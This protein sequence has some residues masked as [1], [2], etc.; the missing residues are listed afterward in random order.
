MTVSYA[1]ALDL[2][3]TKILAAVVDSEG[4]ALAT[5]RLSTDAGRGPDAVADAMADLLQ[6]ACARAGV[7]RETLAGLGVSAAG[8]LDA[9]RGVVSA[10]PNL[11]GWKDVSLGRMLAARTGL[12]VVLENDANAAAVGEHVYGAGRGSRNMVFITVSTGIGGGVI[13]DGRLYRGATGAAGEIGHMIVAHAGERCGC[14]RLGCLEAYASGT[15]IARDAERAAHEGRSPALA[16]MR[17]RGEPLNTEAVAAA[18]EAGDATAAAILARAAEY[19]GVGLENTVHLFN[20]DRIVVGGG[21]SHLAARILDPAVAFMRANAFPA[22]VAGVD[23]VPAAR[24]DG[25]PAVGAA[26]L[27]FAAAREG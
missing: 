24:G 21:V 26:A 19:L 11:P 22:L 14:G 8:P 20:P 18:A 17:A 4:Q 5:E 12:R 16:A 7:A 23:V 25:A 1:G 6:L 2:G 13:V 27:A 10:P 9:A 3:G 15:A